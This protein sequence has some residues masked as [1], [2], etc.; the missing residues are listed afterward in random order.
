MSKTYKMCNVY[1]AYNQKN[2]LIA[3]GFSDDVSAV[4]GCSQRAL[5]GIH[6]EKIMLNKFRVVY[7]G[8]KEKTIEVTAGYT[9][10]QN[11]ETFVE[12]YRELDYYG[13]TIMSQTEYKNHEKLIEDKGYTAKYTKIKHGRQKA[14]YLV[15]VL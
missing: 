9:Y 5:S 1:E 7:L 12:R 3:R 14:C 13:N 15:E 6:D 2:E 4:I 10:K 8:K 11:G